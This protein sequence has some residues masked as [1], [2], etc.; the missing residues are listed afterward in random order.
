MDGRHFLLRHN[1]TIF[2]YP[3]SNTTTATDATD[4]TASATVTTIPRVTR[5]AQ[6]QLATKSRLTSQAA[7]ESANFSFAAAV[8]PVVAVLVVLVVA[9]VVEAAAAAS[10]GINSARFA[11]SVCL[12]VCPLRPSPQSVTPK[13]SI[14]FSVN[15]RCLFSVVFFCRF[16]PVLSLSLATLFFLSYH[17]YNHSVTWINKSITLAKVDGIVH[18]LCCSSHLETDSKSKTGPTRYA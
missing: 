9:V 11:R 14:E 3:G 4:A 13:S 15:Y 7:F 6:Q 18:Y 5:S 10:G 12:C 17:S 2:R 1:S 8:A 16:F